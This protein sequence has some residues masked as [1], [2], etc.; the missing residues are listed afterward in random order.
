M[1]QLPAPNGDQVSQGQ[2]SITHQSQILTMQGRAA[3]LTAGAAAK[4]CCLL[5]F[6]FHRLSGLKK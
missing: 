4:T 3:F 1:G 6:A 5:L 2:M